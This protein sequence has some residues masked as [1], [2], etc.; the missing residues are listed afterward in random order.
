MPEMS[1]KISAE[2]TLEGINSV[3]FNADFRVVDD[4]SSPEFIT[5]HGESWL[6]LLRPHRELAVDKVSG[7]P[8]QITNRCQPNR[9]N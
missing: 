6:Q 9:A 2:W 7:V 3:L 4:S 1:G 5:K 8:D